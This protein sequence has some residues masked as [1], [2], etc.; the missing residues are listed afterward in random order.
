MIY[1]VYKAP[2]TSLFSSCPN[3]PNCP[4]CP[5]TQPGCGV[6]V[7]VLSVPDIL[8]NFVKHTHAL[9]AVLS[10]K[11]FKIAHFIENFDII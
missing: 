8:L 1:I 10:S 5:T 7:G 4:I 6:R 9:Q 2:L 11:C 3:C